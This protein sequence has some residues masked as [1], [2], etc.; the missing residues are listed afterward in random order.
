MN[1]WRSFEV[2]S[3]SFSCGDTNAAFAARLFFRG[4]ADG[5]CWFGSSSLIG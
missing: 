3:S 5:A 4:I 2:R 1:S